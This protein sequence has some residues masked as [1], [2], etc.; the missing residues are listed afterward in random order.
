MTDKIA[1]KVILLSISGYS[2][3]NDALLSQLINEKIRLFCAAGKDCAI[4]EESMDAL[5]VGEGDEKDFEMMTTS[6]P[7]ETFDEV[8]QFAET[9]RIEGIDN[10][11]VTVIQI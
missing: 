1:K 6:H 8:M 4:W 10:K 11:A 5:F 2:A 7:N 3:E 9:F